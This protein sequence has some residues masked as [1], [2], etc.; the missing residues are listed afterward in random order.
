MPELDDPNTSYQNPLPVDES[1]HTTSVGIDQK[2]RG[3]VMATTTTT[4]TTTTSRDGIQMKNTPPPQNEAPESATSTP[5]PNPNP[6]AAS[7]TLTVPY[8]KL[9][10]FADTFDRILMLLGTLGAIGAGLTF[11]FMTILF[12]QVID[13]FGQNAAFNDRVQ[14]EV[15]KV[16]F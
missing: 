1:I 10:T 15:G 9:F 2:N 7:P 12:G 8:F 16:D 13:A 5:D 11:P 6:T 3:S 4:T 14:R